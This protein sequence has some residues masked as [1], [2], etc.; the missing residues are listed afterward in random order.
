MSKILYIDDEIYIT[1]SLCKNLTSIY[2][3]K[4]DLITDYRKFEN[5]LQKG[6]DCIMLD[7]MMPILPS[8][9]TTD[10]LL[11]IK[12]ESKVG[13]VLFNKIR[14]LYPK[15]PIL[16]YSAIS[17]IECDEYSAFLRKPELAKNIADNLKLLIERS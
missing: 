16:F 4:V 9:F 2:G 8:F 12:S 5:E 10:E 15:I 3:F 1:H 13:V 17:S 11:T 7:V 6:Y 14:K